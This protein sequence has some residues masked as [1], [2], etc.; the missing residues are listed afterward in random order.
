MALGA[1]ALAVGVAASIYI[2]WKGWGAADQRPDVRVAPTVVLGD[3]GCHVPADRVPA[4]ADLNRPPGVRRLA[5]VCLSSTAATLEEFQ[6]G[7]YENL[8]DV[9]RFNR[10]LQQIYERM[11]KDFVRSLR[12]LGLSRRTGDAQDYELVPNK[13]G[14]FVGAMV[15]TNHWGM[16]DRD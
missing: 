2:V 10:E 11:P 5:A 4:I 8:L 9:N 1:A 7:Y 6:R 16:R 14:R 15:R 13:E 12:M 3:D